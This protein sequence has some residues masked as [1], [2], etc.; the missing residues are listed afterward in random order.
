MSRRYFRV[1]F[2]VGILTCALP[3]AG[4]TI[5]LSPPGSVPDVLGVWDGFYHTD[6]GA[7]GTVGSDVTQVLHPRLE[8]E[9]TLFGLENGDLSYDL[10]A[11]MTR[12]DFITGTGTT[13]KGKLVFHADLQSFAGRG[14]DAGV[15]S[16]K[17]KLVPSRG[18]ASPISAL[19][20]HPF[21]GAA[22]PDISGNGLGSFVSLPDPT[23]PGDV[24]DPNFKGVGKVRISPRNA[25]GSFAGR[26][27]FFIEPS[28]SPVISWPLLGT[29]S[30]D[31]RIIMI[32][33]GAAG[34]ITYDGVVVPP[35]SSEQQT[36][37]GGFF[38]LRFFDGGSLFGAINFN[39]SRDVID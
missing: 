17:Y 38:R 13:S 3:M 27:E 4:I 25:R 8:G 14:G 21:P 6:D 33:Q 29:T 7:T 30:D 11:T 24:P 26:V 28:P 32:S 37:V 20:L 1:T 36:F 34:K 9:G 15:K 23:I 31:G 12:P 10:R 2:W 39:L 22:A 19:L 35:S 16:A 5:A 18:G